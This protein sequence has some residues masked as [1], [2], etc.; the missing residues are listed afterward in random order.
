M[1]KKLLWKI[2][3][4]AGI[5]TGVFIAFLSV[6]GVMALFRVEIDEILNPSLYS[7][8]EADTHVSL[9]QILKHVEAYHSDKKLFEIYPPKSENGSYVIRL[10]PNK[11]QQLFPVLQEVFY[12][13]YN[14][15]LLGER[16]YYKTISY[17]L[18]NLHVRFYESIWGRQIVGLGGLALLISII[19]GIFIY[20]KF[21]RR[22]AFGTVRNKNKRIL[23]ADYHKLIG[24]AALAFNIVIAITGAWLGLQPLLMKYLNI[25]KPNDIKKEKVWTPEQDASFSF[26]FD[27]VI[28]TVSS[29]YANFEIK[30]IRPST[31]G[32]GLI[33]VF[34]DRPYQ[35]YERSVNKVVLAKNN[36]SVVDAYNPSEDNLTGK[37]YFAQEAL[38]FGDYG[39]MFLKILY[40]ILGLTSAFLVF[41]GFVIRLKNKSK[42]D[43][44]LNVR[45]VLLSWCIG[46]LFFIVVI[47]VLSVL[48]GI[49]IPSLIVT[50]LFYLFILSVL[51]KLVLMR[52]KKYRNDNK[53]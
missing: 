44:Y 45:K 13:P 18:R 36:L 39:G 46:V 5:Y 49:G 22:Q 1:K 42:K 40:A 52:V 33:H 28:N 8:E 47:G 23:Y 6:T 37:L 21:M 12:N 11:K 34:G 10:F 50:L 27:E 31:N 24:V 15:I 17:Y 38:H 25:S 19:T 29:S 43:K 16:N 3:Q 26:N 2:H 48:Y 14:G 51:F 9:N 53:L 7:V 41:S 32:E 35:I 30:S 20:G 4:I